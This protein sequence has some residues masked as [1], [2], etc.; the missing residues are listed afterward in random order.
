MWAP[1]HRSWSFGFA[2]VILQMAGIVTAQPNPVPPRGDLLQL[3]EV[4]FPLTSPFTF[5]L[6]GDH[7]ECHPPS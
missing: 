4:P 3:T 7:S 1:N 5:K 6:S 2:A